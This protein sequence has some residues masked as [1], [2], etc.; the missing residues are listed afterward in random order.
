MIPHATP[1]FIALRMMERGAD[2]GLIAT[3]MTEEHRRGGPLAF[4]E[5]L[6]PQERI[7]LGFDSTMEK[8][9]RHWDQI[10][11]ALESAINT[12]VHIDTSKQGVLP[13]FTIFDE[14]KEW[15]A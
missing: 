2:A 1:T 4:A 15:R 13:D 12:F 8:M 7:T 5:L 6:T 9:A 3:Y 11:S 10:S 14:T